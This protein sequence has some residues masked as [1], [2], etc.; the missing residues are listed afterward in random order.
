M[1][2]IRIYRGEGVARSRGHRREGVSGA[3][4]HRGE[5]VSGSLLIRTLPAGAGVM[6]NASHTYTHSHMTHRGKFELVFVWTYFIEK[7]C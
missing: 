5:S 4:G 6:G 3:G 7:N 1:A 2:R